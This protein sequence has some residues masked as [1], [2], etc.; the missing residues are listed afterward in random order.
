MTEGRREYEREGAVRVLGESP[1][2]GLE[3]VGVSD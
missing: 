1:V 2:A 3:V